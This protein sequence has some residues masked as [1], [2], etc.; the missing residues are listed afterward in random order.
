MIRATIVLLL[1]SASALAQP[2]T[3]T[4]P[5]T[6]KAKA[7]QAAGIAAYK[8]KDFATASKEFAAAYAAESYDGFLFSRAQSDRQRGECASAVEL[9][10]R[11]LATSPAPD[12]AQA[13][14]DGIAACGGSSATP[15]PAPV[16][17][18]NIVADDTLERPER[19]T[20]RVVWPHKLAVGLMMTGVLFGGTSAAFYVSARRAAND[21]DRAAEHTDVTT[22]YERAENHLAASRISLGIS[23]AFVAASVIRFVL[24]DAP[25]PHG[26]LVVG[27]SPGGL[28]IAGAF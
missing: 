15:A 9:Y 23:A 20:E 4:G 11:F 14:R 10:E 17:M 1:A 7:H 6:E 25:D 28:S 8:A 27:V 18:P 21:A 19:S 13:S 5:T 26:D 22:L 3:P 12:F 2:A 24:T 16:P